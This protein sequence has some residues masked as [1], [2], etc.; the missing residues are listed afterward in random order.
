MITMDE[1]EGLRVPDGFTPVVGFRRF[2][3]PHPL[4]GAGHDCLVQL[5]H[6]WTPQAPTIAKCRRMPISCGDRAPTQY[7]SCGLHAWLGIEEALEYRELT[8][9]LGWVMASVIGWGRVFFDED[10]WRAE[11]AQVIAFADP[12]DTHS[13]RPEVV[14]EAVGEWVAKV[15]VDYG[16]PVLPLDELREYTLM[17]GEE[18]E[19]SG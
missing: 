7:C 17:Y 14:Q 18:Y 15:A 3:I 2:G 12:R 1:I 16:A 4:S 11:M 6:R 8:T 9:S 13:N 19:E 5:G 10:F